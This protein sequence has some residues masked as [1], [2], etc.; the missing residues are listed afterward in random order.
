MRPRILALVTAVAA[1]AAAATPA[2]AITIT[3]FT[4]SATSGVAGAHP[5][6]TTSFSF[7]NKPGAAS[8]DGTLRTIRLDLPPGLIGDPHGASRCAR[9]LF[10]Q[11]TCP[12]SSQVG[13]ATA[14]PAGCAGDS[15]S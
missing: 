5:D 9:D 12:A 13:A 3:S 2:H 6:V 4:T 15:R 10:S 1:L 7:A 11:G 14:P 8:V